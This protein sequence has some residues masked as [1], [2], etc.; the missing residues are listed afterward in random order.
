MLLIVHVK[1]PVNARDCER[2][3]KSKHGMTESK[4]AAHCSS[5]GVFCI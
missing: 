1:D 4:W 3:V 2:V 5:S